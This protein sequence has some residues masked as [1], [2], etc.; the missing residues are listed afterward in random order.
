MAAYVYFDARP[1]RRHVDEDGK[2]ATQATQ[3]GE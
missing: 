1:I 3:C 2:R